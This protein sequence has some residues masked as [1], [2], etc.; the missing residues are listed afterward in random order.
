MLSCRIE[1]L[2]TGGTNVCVGV[3]TSVPGASLPVCAPGSCP[4]QPAIEKTIVTIAKRNVCQRWWWRDRP[5]VFM[6]IPVFKIMLSPGRKRF[7]LCSL[8]S[9]E[10]AR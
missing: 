8:Q 6:I 5:P 4:V 9:T 2:K 1:L 3:G 7:A 10:C